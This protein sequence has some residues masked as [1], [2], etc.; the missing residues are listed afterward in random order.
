[1]VMTLMNSVETV[2][3]LMAFYY[4]GHLKREYGT[5]D[6]VAAALYTLGFV[7]RPTSAF[8]SVPLVFLQVFKFGLAG[9]RNL[10]K[11][12][13]IVALPMLLVAVGIDSWYYG[14]LQI[15]MLNFLKTNVLAGISHQYGVQEH[16]WYFT[17]GLPF[18]LLSYIPFTIYALIKVWPVLE[19]RAIFYITITYTLAMSALAHKEDRF[20][21][22]VLPYYIIITAYGLMR[23][24]TISRLAGY[25]FI[26]VSIVAQ[27]GYLRHY[28]SVFRVSAF[29]TMA[30][31]RAIPPHELRSVYFFVLCHTTP[32]YSHI[33]RYY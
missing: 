8:I 23:I 2:I 1:M 22:P 4:W 9:L 26:V 20:I 14:R 5:T 24:K 6:R 16:E 27:F 33:H 10:F 17:V 21:T 30:E 19:D 15:T 13:C 29:P 32:F 31:L 12:F 7:L 25:L 28:S 3:M 18:V 11:A